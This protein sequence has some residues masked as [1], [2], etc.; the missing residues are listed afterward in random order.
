MPF[1]HEANSQP[2]KKPKPA[3]FVRNAEIG[4]LA[5]IL[6]VEQACTLAA[7][8][9]PDHY[10]N[11]IQSQPQGACFLV[12]ESEDKKEEKE[13]K[14]EDKNKLCGFLC[15]QIVGIA[16]EWEIENVVVDER[17]RRQGIGAQ[18]MRS[19]IEKWEASSGLSLMLE[20]RE[21]NTAARALYERYGFRETGRRRA[22]YREPSE[23]AIFYA[24]HRKG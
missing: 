7:H 20:V 10:R 14:K 8:W 1:N 21:S 16:G 15:A 19:L 24:S 2:V 5:A 3:T 9:N 11:R 12:A 18:L 13:D 4:D 22:Y 17:L 6:A 23:D